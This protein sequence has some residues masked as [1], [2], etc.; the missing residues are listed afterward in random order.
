MSETKISHHTHTHSG[1]ELAVFYHHPRY[2]KGSIYCLAWLGDSLLASGSNDQ[3]VRLLSYNSSSPSP[4]TPQ[5][6]LNVHNGTVRDLVFLPDGHLLSGGAGDSALKLSD[7]HTGRLIHSFTGHTD[8]ILSV[9]VVSDTTIVSGGQDKTVRLWDT[10]HTRCLHTIKVPHPA[11]S[12]STFGNR[13]TTSQ[14][15]GSCSIYN[16]QTL[17]SIGTFH[18]HT[19]ECR[20]VRYSPTG[21]WL[22]TGSYDGTLC[23]ANVATLEWRV[24]GQHEDKVIQCRWHSGEKLLVSTGADKK[25]C[26]WKLQY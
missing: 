2:H 6:Q 20:T 1:D 8:Q 21:R 10:R 24:V 7:V 3:T 16:L 12:L 4:C 17:K 23:I 25:A 5:G 11:T 9:A 18:P 15:D 26:F 19:D 13:I 14:L 22:L